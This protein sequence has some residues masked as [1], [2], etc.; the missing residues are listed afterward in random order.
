[1]FDLVAN[2]PRRLSPAEIER[3]QK[4]TGDPVRMRWRR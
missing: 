2:R 3:M 1:M 4:W